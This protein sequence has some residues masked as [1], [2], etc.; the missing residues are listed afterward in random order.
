MLSETE[1]AW[2]A[3]FLEGEGSFSLEHHKSNGS[4]YYDYP[5]IAVQ[6]TDYDVLERAAKLMDAPGI[7]NAKKANVNCKPCWQ[8][9]VRNDKAITIMNQILPYMGARRAGKIREVLGHPTGT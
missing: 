3:G 7:W 9:R 5:A 4:Y 6:S 2:L 1:I 8:I